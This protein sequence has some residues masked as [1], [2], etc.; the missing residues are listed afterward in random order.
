MATK[1]SASCKATTGE[2]TYLLRMFY[3]MSTI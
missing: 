1:L 3:I 2:V